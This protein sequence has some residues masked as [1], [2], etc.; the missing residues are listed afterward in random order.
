VS[1]L[2]WVPPLA[3]PAP[4]A[5]VSAKAATRT[6]IGLGR[7]S[8]SFLVNAAGE[9]LGCRCSRTRCEKGKRL[10]KGLQSEKRDAVEKPCLAR[11][12]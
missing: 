6:I 11:Q 1:A 10:V 3:E 12:S 5:A 7:I 9:R 8:A 4:I 2:P